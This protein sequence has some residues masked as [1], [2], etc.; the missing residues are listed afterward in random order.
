VFLALLRI[1]GTF[2]LTATVFVEQ[3]PA[4][5]TIYFGAQ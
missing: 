5:T 3:P 1:D 4:E 2:E